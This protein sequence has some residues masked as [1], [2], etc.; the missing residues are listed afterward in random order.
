MMCRE[1][2][3]DLATR[4]WIWELAD[5][6][7]DEDQKPATLTKYANRLRVVLQIA[8]GVLVFAFI[9]HDALQF[10]AGH[11]TVSTVLRTVGEALAFSAAIDLAYMLFT[12]GPD[13]AVEPVIVGIAAT[14]MILVSSFKENIV[15]SDPATEH[16]SAAVSHNPHFSD[17]NMLWPVLSVLLL[18]GAIALLFY[19]RARYL[20]RDRSRPNENPPALDN[21]RALPPPP[22]S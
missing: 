11:G 10:L 2:L 9:A 4:N 16:A 14:V 13:E 18:V 21:A 22:S 17:Y 1:K 19:I 12:P 8:L 6:S 7:F 3:R 20:K 5:S 15:G